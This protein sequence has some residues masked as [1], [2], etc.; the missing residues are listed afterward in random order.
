MPFRLPP[1]G[2]HAF[3]GLGQGRALSRQRR[4]AGGLG[5][6]QKRERFLGLAAL[7]FQRQR[8]GQFVLGPLQLVAQRLGRRDGIGNA[9][10]LGFRQSG[11]GL[12]AALAQVGRQRHQR[13]APGGGKARH[14]GLGIDFARALASARFS[15]S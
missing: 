4:V 6:G 11:A 14:L 5:G 13:L 3:F 2:P 8:R 1:E 9:R 7:F 15:A 10:R 12:G